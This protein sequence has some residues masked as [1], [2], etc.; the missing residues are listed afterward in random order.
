MPRHEQNLRGF[1]FPFSFSSMDLCHKKI[2]TLLYS[3]FFILYGY[4]I[5][6]LYMHYLF[7]IVP[8][9]FMFALNS[10]HEL[11]HFFFSHSH[12]LE[13]EDG[14]GDE[15]L[16]FIALEPRLA[17]TLTCSCYSANSFLIC[18]YFNILHYFVFSKSP[19]RCTSESA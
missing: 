2:Y 15:E 6:R 1:F 13:E 5:A 10:E 7:I 9:V 16:F 12:R 4:I 18:R 14:D 11:A 3:L 19:V 17:E 8:L